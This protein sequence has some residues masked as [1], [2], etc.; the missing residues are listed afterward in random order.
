MASPLKT[1][2]ASGRRPF[3]GDISPGVARCLLLASGLGAMAMFYLS[4]FATARVL[5][6]DSGLGRDGVR[7]IAA[8]ACALLLLQGLVP[9]VRFSV[10]ELPRLAKISLR[11]HFREIGLFVLLL[12]AAALLFL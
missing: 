6:A 1:S 3:F 4:V 5:A 9:I 8:L 2:A 10:L 12:I 11:T 7:T